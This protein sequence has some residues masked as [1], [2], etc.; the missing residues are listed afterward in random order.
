MWCILC[1]NN[2]ILN[3]NPK[4]QARKGLII[5]NS[6][7]GII[8]LRKQVNLDHPNI[9]LKIE[10]KINCPLREDEKQ[11]SKKISNVYSNYIP[12]FFATK[13]PFKKN[14]V[15]QKQFLEDLTFLIVK[16]HISLQFVEN[17]WLKKFSIHLCFRIVFPSRKQ[18]FNEL[19]LGLVEKTRQLYV[20]LVLVEYH[21]AIANFDLWMSKVGHDI[22]HW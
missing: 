15:Q 7:N 8:T 10:E 1:H 6:F 19:L 21:F 5:Y 22:L 12:S 11:P 14:D 16:N 18:I 2:S 17:S 20:L 3:V 4:T 13:E 9:F